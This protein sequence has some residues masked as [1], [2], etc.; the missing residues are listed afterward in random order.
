M[1]TDPAIVC[2]RARWGSYFVSR[3][4]GEC[5]VL[6]SP[7]AF[8]CLV[9]VQW[10]TVPDGYLQWEFDINCLWRLLIKLIDSPRT[11]EPDN[12]LDGSERSENNRIQPYTFYLPQLND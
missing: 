8:A 9:G 2:R 6:K 3:G 7:H 10:W 11:V 4:H 1:C 5:S 12:V